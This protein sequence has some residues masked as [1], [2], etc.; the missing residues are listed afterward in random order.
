MREIVIDNH[1]HI[2]KDI[3]HGESNIEGYM[4]FAKKTG[5][6]VGLLM[7]VPSPC[8]ELGNVNSRIMYWKYNG[9]KMEY[10]GDKNPYKTLNYEL[11]ELL[12]ENTSEELQLFFVPM[13]HPVLDDIDEFEQMLKKTEPVA[14]KVHGIGS[15]VGPDDISGEYIELLKN[16]DLPLIV[17]TD[18]D[19]GKGS[20]SMQ[21]VRNINRGYNW[22]KF[23]EN[24]KIKGILNHGAS[25]DQNTFKIVNHSEYIKVALGPDKIACLDNN[26]L[27]VDCLGNYKNFLLYLKDNLDISKIIYDADYNWNVKNISDQDFDSVKRVHEIFNIDDSKKV[28][29]K[30]LIDFNTKIRERLEKR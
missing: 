18:C 15:G 26:R 1:S 3:F 17:H 30:N 24:N 28:L 9:N 25:L 5:I 20:V 16:Y 19:N 7:G 14:I 27:F 23:F 29:S 10:Y 21:Y 6:N 2:G 13:F 12:K 11:A 22:A 4:D 8:N